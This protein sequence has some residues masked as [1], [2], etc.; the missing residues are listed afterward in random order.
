MKTLSTITAL[1]AAAAFAASGTGFAQEH[2]PGKDS[3]EHA[4]KADEHHAQ[5]DKHD[6]KADEHHANA[7]HHE[8]ADHH[9]DA[10]H[11]AGK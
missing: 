7:E 5:T 6:P 8:G 3:H 4:P 2:A 1:V 9:K 10:A 11:Q